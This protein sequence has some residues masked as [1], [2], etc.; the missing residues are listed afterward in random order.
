[1]R[2]LQ[3]EGGAAEPRGSHPIPL[4]WGVLGAQRVTAGARQDLLAFLLPSKPQTHQALGAAV[5]AIC[6]SAGGCR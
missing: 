4:C 5:C 3:Q 1:M 6:F 2:L